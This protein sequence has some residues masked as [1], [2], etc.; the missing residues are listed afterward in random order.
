MDSIRRSFTSEER[1]AVWDRS[2]GT[3]AY[4]G[5]QLHP[6]RDFTIDH[7]VPLALGGSNALDNLTAACRP[8]NAS[9]S[10]RS[11]ETFLSHKHRKGRGTD[12]VI[13]DSVRLAEFRRDCSRRYGVDHHDI[14]PLMAKLGIRP[15]RKEH[16]HAWRIWKDDAKTVTQHLARGERPSP[17]LPKRA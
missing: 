16:G 3:C 14:G 10:V 11:V 9:K 4:C 5:K 6:F 8:C 12:P 1:A 17:S 13:Q 7:M 15:F 2:G